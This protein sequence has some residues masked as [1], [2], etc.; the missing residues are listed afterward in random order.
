MPSSDRT[1]DLERARKSMTYSE[2]LLRSTA[3]ARVLRDTGVGTGDRLVLHLPNGLAQ[4]VWL[5]A[6][7]RVGAVYAC[8]PTTLSTKAPPQHR[9]AR[10]CRRL[11]E[12]SASCSRRSRTAWPT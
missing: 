9:V 11:R 10:S 5:Q 8:L 4:L 3:A 1:T 2:L 12:P 7:K 6:A